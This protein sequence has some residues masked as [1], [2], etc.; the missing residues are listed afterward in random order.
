MGLYNNGSTNL[1][2]LCVFYECCMLDFNK[3][4]GFCNFVIKSPVT[5]APV[6]HV[7]NGEFVNRCM[8]NYFITE[9]CIYNT[10]ENDLMVLEKCNFVLDKSLKSPGISFWKKCGNFVLASALT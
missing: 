1:I 9:K 2:C 3:S 6:I 10:P 7:F 8:A 5:T 4:M